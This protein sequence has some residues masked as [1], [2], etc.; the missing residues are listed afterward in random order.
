MASWLSLVEA[1]SIPPLEFNVKLI[2]VDAE[3]RLGFMFVCGHGT[4]ATAVKNIGC[5]VAWL[6]YVN[7]KKHHYWRRLHLRYYPGDLVWY[8]PFIQGTR[9]AL[10]HCCSISILYCYVLRLHPKSA[11]VSSAV[12]H[13]QVRP[14]I[15][16]TSDRAKRLAGTTDRHE[17]R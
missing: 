7:K 2:E 16:D 9:P 4:N 11:S 10:I 17:L 6:E 13:S 5:L 15:A 1:T 8:F 3:W 14:V 12:L